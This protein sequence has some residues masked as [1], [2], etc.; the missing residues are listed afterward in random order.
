MKPTALVG[1]ASRRASPASTVAV[2][3]TA[4][5]LAG[6]SARSHNASIFTG[7]EVRTLVAK[8]KKRAKPKKPVK[9]KKPVRPAPKPQPPRPVPPEGLPPA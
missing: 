6:E 1:V 5:L 2:A 4:R 3:A 7:N 8:A 9:A